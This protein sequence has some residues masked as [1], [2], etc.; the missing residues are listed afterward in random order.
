LVTLGFGAW[1]SSNSGNDF[2]SII[3]VVGFAITLSQLARF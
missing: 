1:A 3:L 2:L